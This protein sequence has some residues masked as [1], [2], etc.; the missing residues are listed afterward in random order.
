MPSNCLVTPRPF[1]YSQKSFRWHHKLFANFLPGRRTYQQEVTS[2]LPSYPSRTSLFLSVQWVRWYTC[3]QE[4][5]ATMCEWRR[6][7]GGRGIFH[8]PVVRALIAMELA[9]TFS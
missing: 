4:S 9:L 2:S 1:V 5:E 3:S 6:L 8:P 7:L